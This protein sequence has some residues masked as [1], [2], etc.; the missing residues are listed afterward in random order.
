M[1]LC[2][3]FFSSHLTQSQSCAVTHLFQGYD[4]TIEADHLRH[5]RDQ[6]Q[7]DKTAPRLDQDQDG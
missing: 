1:F 4:L 3:H 5:Q 2:Q 6:W 7:K